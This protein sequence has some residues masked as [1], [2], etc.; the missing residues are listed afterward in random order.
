MVA[1]TGMVPLFVAVN[2]P[3]FPEPLAAKPIEGVLLTQ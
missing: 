1:V 3:I 2:A